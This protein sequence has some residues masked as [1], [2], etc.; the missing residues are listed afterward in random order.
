MNRECKSDD[1][2]WKRIFVNA[3]RLW[4][5][6]RCDTV[7]NRGEISPP[8]HEKSY[9]L[10]GRR[11]TEQEIEELNKQRDEW[12]RAKQ[13]EFE[14][15]AKDFIYQWSCQGRY[16]IWDAY[17]RFSQAAAKLA[18][19]ISVYPVKGDEHKSDELTVDPSIKEA[20]K[21]GLTVDPPGELKTERPGKLTII[22]R[23]K[24]SKNSSTE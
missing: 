13:E 9:Y 5:C 20:A 4:E 12:A 18:H 19:I 24:I 21:Q 22:G 1:H 15:P 10:F 7:S 14:K 11:C 23:R 17:K 16:E 8:D 2:V 6:T 3:L